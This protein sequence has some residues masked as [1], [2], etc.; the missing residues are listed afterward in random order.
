VN[1]VSCESRVSPKL[2]HGLSIVL[3]LARVST[4][5]ICLEMWDFVSNAQGG[6]GL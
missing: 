6:G 5:G 3:Y 4:C 2:V 1:P